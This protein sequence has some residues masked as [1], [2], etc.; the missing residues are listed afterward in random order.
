MKD[1]SIYFQPIAATGSFSAAQLGS[2]ID[3]NDGD[4]PELNEPGCAIIEVSEYRGAVNGC[5]HQIVNFREHL[6]ALHPETS[7][8]K[9]IYDLGT[10]LPGATIEDTYFAVASV[11]AELVKHNIIPIIIG[12]SQDLTMALYLGYEQLEQLVNTCSIDRGLDIGEPEAALDSSNFLSHIVTRR[13]CYLF[14]HDNS[15][16]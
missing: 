9:K 5:G 11:V 12:G 13:P 4:F 16:N 6:Y 8:D 14:N 2:Y 15:G 1:L 3:A 7:W 10:I